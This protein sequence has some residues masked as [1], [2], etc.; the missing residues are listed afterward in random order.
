MSGVKSGFQISN[1]MRYIRKL[2]SSISSEKQLTGGSGAS[3]SP[4]RWGNHLRIFSSSR[5]I[6]Q[7]A[8]RLPAPDDESDRAPDTHPPSSGMSPAALSRA[9]LRRPRLGHR[10]GCRLDGQWVGNF[11]WVYK[12]CV[13]WWWFASLWMWRWFLKSGALNVFKNTHKINI[14]TYNIRI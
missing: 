9:R 2:F 5:I 3:P 10:K 12:W 13:K 7:R 1:P 14:Y 11:W 4:S 6:T 8:D